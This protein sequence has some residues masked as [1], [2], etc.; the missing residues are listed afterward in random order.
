LLTATR[1]RSEPSGQL[2]NGYL[3]SITSRGVTRLT[4]CRV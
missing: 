1:R 4:V 2:G 3:E